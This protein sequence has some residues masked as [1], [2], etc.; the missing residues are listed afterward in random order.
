MSREI[1]GVS[2][3]CAQPAPAWTVVRSTAAAP[4]R[5][6]LG[7]AAMTLSGVGPS[8]NSAVSTPVVASRP[9]AVNSPP[10]RL[11]AT[12]ARVS[13]GLACQ[14]MRSAWPTSEGS[15]LAMVRK[16]TSAILSVW[17]LQL[18]TVSSP[19]SSGSFCML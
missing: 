11:S 2:R 7:S 4:T 9:N 10:S 12:V 8:L 15:R 16:P 19:M 6:R 13:R 14:A 1:C 5:A 18:G 3:D 17:A